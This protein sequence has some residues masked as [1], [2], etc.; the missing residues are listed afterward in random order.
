[1]RTKKII[2]KLSLSE[3]DLTEKEKI[4]ILR[5]ILHYPGQPTTTEVMQLE[6]ILKNHTHH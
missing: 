1:M 2:Q 4:E 6:D 5:I 3:F